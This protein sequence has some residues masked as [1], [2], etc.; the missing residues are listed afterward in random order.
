[1]QIDCTYEIATYPVD[2]GDHFHFVQ[3]FFVLTPCSV[4]LDGP[5]LDY[6]FL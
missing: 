2:A 5:R 3:G 1:M 6:G 4:P